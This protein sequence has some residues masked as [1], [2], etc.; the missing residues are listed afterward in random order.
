V[1]VP[2]SRPQL[3][4]LCGH[5]SHYGNRRPALARMIDRARPYREPVRTEDDPSVE[6]LL[7]AADLAVRG[8][9]FAL[10]AAVEALGLQ[11]TEPALDA[12][13]AA[14]EVGALYGESMSADA[15]L[16]AAY[17]LMEG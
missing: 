17:R 14:R 13:F 11:F 1:F 9:A 5:G 16:E 15:Y 7:C 3:T 2:S 10:T 4:R 8:V 6:L 12:A